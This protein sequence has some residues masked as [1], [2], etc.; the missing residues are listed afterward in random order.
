MASHISEYIEQSDTEMTKQLHR[1]LFD[2]MF[3]KMKSEFPQ[4][5]DDIVRIYI[6]NMMAQTITNVS[7]I[8]TTR[9]TPGES[10]NER[11]LRIVQKLAD[12]AKK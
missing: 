10:Q 6:Q 11:E 9:Q 2:D 1:M 7:N 5:S 3:A 8:I 12:A 4:I